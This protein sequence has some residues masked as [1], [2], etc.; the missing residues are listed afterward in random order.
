MLPARKPEL[1]VKRSGHGEIIMSK[2]AIY[3][4]KKTV[5]DGTIKPWP[6]IDKTDEEMVLASLRGNQHQ[7][8]PN[9]VALQKEF[10]A[11]NGNKFCVT[12][13]SGTAENPG[14]ALDNQLCTS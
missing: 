1:I 14:S 4:G 10:A 6:P 13:N 12:T 8:G 9:C 2:L 5:P 3:G 11:W 7:F